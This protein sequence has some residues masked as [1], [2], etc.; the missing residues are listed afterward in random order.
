[1]I[2][3]IDGYN[4]LFSGLGQA[5]TTKPNHLETLRDNLVAQLKS[6]NIRKKY[7]IIVV[8]DGDKAVSHYPQERESGNVRVVFS[9]GRTTADEHIINLVSAY[10]QDK[11]RRSDV[12]AVTSDRALAETLGHR[13]KVVSSQEFA[14]ELLLKDK[15]IPTTIKE[16]P[17]EKFTGLKP[18]DVPKWLKIFRTTDDTDST[19]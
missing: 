14:V 12:S 6:Y 10:I 19:D 8:F 4:L 18:A 16:D 2:L 7:R 15:N 3:I 17:I 1:M 5:D 9:Q 11:P 13:V